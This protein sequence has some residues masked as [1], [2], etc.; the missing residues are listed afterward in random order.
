K[1]VQ[2]LLDEIEARTQIRLPLVH[3]APTNN[4]P[5]IQI[6]RNADVPVGPPESYKLLIEPN[7]IQLTPT[8]S[9]GLLFGVGR[10]LRELKLSRQ[11]IDLPLPS[12]SIQHSS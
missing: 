6:Q 1:A 9:R 5:T 8:D 10:L 12:F 2:L 7:Q 11:H 3:T 4:S